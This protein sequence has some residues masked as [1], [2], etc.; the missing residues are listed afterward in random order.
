MGKVRE[1]PT[2]AD[3]FHALVRDCRVQS[4]YKDVSGRS[5][6]ASVDTLLS[7]LQT[8]GLSIERPSDAGR[9]LQDRRHERQL[10]GI[11]PVHIA[12]NGLLRP[13]QVTVP[14]DAKPRSIEFA[15]GKDGQLVQGSYLLDELPVDTSSQSERGFT[16]VRL[17]MPKRLGTG[18]YDLE[19]SAAAGYT[20]RLSS[21][22]LGRHTPAYATIKL[23]TAAMRTVMR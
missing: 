21:H 12:W 5:C 15:L 14:A 6:R 4:S 10:R 22:R 9:L 3:E 18:Y 16:N 13:I 1:Q 8:L 11:E 2:S 7:V 17:P 19:V 23:R 20:S